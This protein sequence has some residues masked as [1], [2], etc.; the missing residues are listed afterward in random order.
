MNKVEISGN[1]SHE[2]EK[3]ELANGTISISWRVKVA[4]ES[5]GSDSIPCVINE[6]TATKSLLQKVE[7]LK[8]G[9]AVEISG[10]LRSRYWQGPGGNS[11]RIEVEVLSI[12]KSRI[13]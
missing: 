3:R 8:I 2:P 13:R 1:I 9:Q 12:K 5:T 7:N 4:K 11:S 10:E 6:L